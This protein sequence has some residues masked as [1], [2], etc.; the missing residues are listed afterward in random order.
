ML[1]YH[2]QLSKDN[3][4]R[5]VGRATGAIAADHHTCGAPS[6]WLVKQ[7]SF[8]H[9]PCSVRQAGLCGTL[10]EYCRTDDM[11]VERVAK[12]AIFNNKKTF[13]YLHRLMCN[14]STRMCRHES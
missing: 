4:A 8:T 11:H 14:A 9:A 3:S 5:L 12:A 1:L 6:P 10:L 7:I 2:R 13:V